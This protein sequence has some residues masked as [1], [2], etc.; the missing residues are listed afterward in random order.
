MSAPAVTHMHHATMQGFTN[1]ANVRLRLPASQG[2]RKGSMIQCRYPHMRRA[3]LLM[4]SQLA[5]RAHIG[6]SL[7]LLPA[8]RSFTLRQPAPAGVRAAR[9]RRFPPGCCMWRCRTAAAA[10]AAWI[11]K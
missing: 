9:W 1:N 3:A 4:A 10:R 11:A 8:T 6:P 5:G 2:A 7:L